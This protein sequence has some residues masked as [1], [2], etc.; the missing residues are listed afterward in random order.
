MYLMFPVYYF[1]YIFLSVRGKNT[2]S[3]FPQILS[4]VLRLTSPYSYQP[5][6]SLRKHILSLVEHL[7][8]Q[9]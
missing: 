9:Y 8:D 7:F 2:S 5:C 1:S 6:S 3:D 4:T